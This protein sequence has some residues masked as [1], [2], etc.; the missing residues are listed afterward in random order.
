MLIATLLAC[1]EYGL[2]PH[3]PK[4]E[5]TEHDGSGDSH[6]TRD[7]RD[8]TPSDDDGPDPDPDDPP[9]HPP[10]ESLDHDC[11]EDQLA[12]FSEDEIW[13]GAHGNTTAS[14][15]LHAPAAGWYHVY[16]THIVE[17]GATQHNESVFFHV[18][19]ATHPDGLPAFGNCGDDYVVV[20]GD[21]DGPPAGNQTLIGTFWLDAGDNELVMTHYCT[22][23]DQGRCPEHHIDQPSS[24]TCDTN[25]INSVHFMGFGVCLVPAQ[26]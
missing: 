22:L 12:V 2:D 25:N 26:G 15:A 11:P 24:Q 23:Y 8:P 10:A 3:Q 17:S 16:N 1:S 13:V 18:P 14:G 7:P 4:P 19:N 21:N 6:D 5:L 9:E 20:D